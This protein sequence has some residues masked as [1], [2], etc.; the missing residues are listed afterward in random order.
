MEEEEDVEEEECESAVHRVHRV[1]TQDW[2]A[3]QQPPAARV[4]WSVVTLCYTDE[5]KDPIVNS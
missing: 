3:G 5:K 1:H 2:P 4:C